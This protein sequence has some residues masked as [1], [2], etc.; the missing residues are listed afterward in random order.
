LNL[1]PGHAQP[2]LFLWL[3]GPP[4]PAGTAAAAIGCD[5]GVNEQQMFDT[6]Q[7]HPPRFQEP[8]MKKFA[9]AALAAVVATVSFSSVA[10]AG[11]RYHH[12][13]HGGVYFAPRFVVR[14]TR[15][16]VYDNYCFVKKVRHYDD[17]GNMYVSRVRVCN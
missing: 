4:V 15:V 2:G 14:P 11:W 1:K 5:N 8:P 16:V 13:W 10:E 7:I 3:F 9:F 17:W 6:D 12:R